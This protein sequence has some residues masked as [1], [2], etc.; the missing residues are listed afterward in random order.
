MALTEGVSFL[1]EKASMKT[2][3][4]PR[5][6]IKAL[7]DEHVTLT[8]EC[9]AAV[10]RLESGKCMVRPVEWGWDSFADCMT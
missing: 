10:Y 6:T 8:V 5:P 9:L 3:P 7:M 4:K 1:V 2:Q